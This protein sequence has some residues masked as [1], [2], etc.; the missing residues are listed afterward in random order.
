MLEYNQKRK[1]IRKNTFR[2]E[3]I[4][5]S[6]SAFHTCIVSSVSN[7][8]YE[9][10]N[11]FR[12][13]STIDIFQQTDVFSVFLTTTS[14]EDSSEAFVYDISRNPHTAE[15]FFDMICKN[16]VTALSLREIAE[17]FISSQF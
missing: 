17:D 15:Q 14:P 13:I 4:L 11:H 2:K 5:I 8:E 1:T 9:I 16:N 10:I 7:T 3:R 6:M 12:L